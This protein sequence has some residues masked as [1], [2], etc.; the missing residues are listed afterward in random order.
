MYIW[1]YQL[2]LGKEMVLFCHDMKFTASVH[3]FPSFSTK[4]S[5]CHLLQN[6]LSGYHEYCKCSHIS[7]ILHQEKQ[8]PP[9]TKVFVQILNQAP[10]QR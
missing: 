8:L 1:Q 2:G 9:I 4:R 5:S 7:L 6:F 10:C 3:T